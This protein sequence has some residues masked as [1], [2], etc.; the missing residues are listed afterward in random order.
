M[1]GHAC[2]STMIV[3]TNLQRESLEAELETCHCRISNI[4]TASK[5]CYLDGWFYEW[6]RSLGKT[7]LG[8]EIGKKT[9]EE[10]VQS[11]K[12]AIVFYLENGNGKRVGLLKEVAIA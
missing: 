4:R 12:N 2:F 6:D 7:T 1:Y 5:V 9:V 10:R 8:I 11:Y 3:S